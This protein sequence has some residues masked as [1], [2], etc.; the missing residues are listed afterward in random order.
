MVRYPVN[1]CFGPRQRELYDLV[2]NLGQ[3]S[4]DTATELVVDLAGRKEYKRTPE[5]EQERRDHQT[6]LDALEEQR[7][8]ETERMRREIL[9]EAEEAESDLIVTATDG[10]NGVLDAFRGSFTERIVERAPCPVLAVPA[11][12]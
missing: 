2:L 4:L 1:G 10:R 12:T 6:R 8:E 7:S 5:L 9:A 3:M 11:P